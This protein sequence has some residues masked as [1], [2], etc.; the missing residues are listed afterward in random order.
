GASN[1]NNLVSGLSADFK[2]SG[3]IN[4][5]IVA[6][7][8]FVA[9]EGFQL[10]INAVEEMK[11]PDRNI[12]RAIYMAIFLAIVI[13]VVISLGAILAIPTQDIIKNKEFALAAGAGKVLGSFGSSIVILGAILATSSAISGTLFGASR[14]IHAVSQDGYFPKVFSKLDRKIPVRAILLMLVVSSLLIL[15]GGLKL[16]L[17][18]GSITFLLTSLIIAVTNFKLRKETK[19]ANWFTLFVI[20][21]LTIGAAL[22]LYYE[23][24][25]NLKQMLFILSL[26]G[27]LTIF[28]SIYAIR[29]KKSSVAK[30]HLG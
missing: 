30:D 13:Y 1:L 26:Y 4:V 27:V 7:I 28:A 18:F 19:S 16:I 2:S 25:Y 22:I 23:F 3:I 29:K 24:K 14:Q 15:V 11:N 10:V 17:E 21:V 20:I 12:P 5:L 8:T 6:S 9:Y